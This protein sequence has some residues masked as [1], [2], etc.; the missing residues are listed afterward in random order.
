MSHV[1]RRGVFVGGAGV[2]AVALQPEVAHAAASTTPSTVPF[3]LNASVLD[4]GEQVTSLTLDTSGFDPVDPASLTTSTFT[5]HAKATSPIP[6]APPDLIFSEYD[7]DRTVT[8]ARL[9]HGKV[10]LDLETRDLA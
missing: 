4:G 7:L 1:T 5:V 9:D 10:I 2:A 6:V 3:S 8:A